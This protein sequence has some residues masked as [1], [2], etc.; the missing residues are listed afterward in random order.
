MDSKADTVDSTQ[1][2]KSVCSA[3][4]AEST[5]IPETIIIYPND[6]ELQKLAKCPHCSMKFNSENCVPITIT[7]GQTVCKSC[8]DQTLCAN[9]YKVHRTNGEYQP[10]AKNFVVYALLDKMSLLSDEKNIETEYPDIGDHIET[11]RYVK[12]ETDI[13]RRYLKSTLNDYKD[14]DY[15]LVR[16]RYLQATQSL[17]WFSKDVENWLRDFYEPVEGKSTDNEPIKMEKDDV[18]MEA[19]HCAVC[20]ERYNKTNYAPFSAFCGHTFCRKCFYKFI[21]YEKKY[22]FDCCLCCV[23]TVLGSPS[24]NHTAIKLLEKLNLLADNDD[25]TDMPSLDHKT[26]IDADRAATIKRNLVIRACERYVEIDLEVL[27][28]QKK[29]ARF[30]AVKDVRKQILQLRDDLIDENPPAVRSRNNN[31]ADACTAVIFI[32]TYGF[33]ILFF[34]ACMAVLFIATSHDHDKRVKKHDY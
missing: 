7:C 24:A 34:L 27:K 1:D 22:F 18:L 12:T 3:N 9:L 32:L 13:L 10:W 33:A 31:F 14:F 30:P 25:Q 17:D 28:F 4:S 15:I 2:T 8:V 23:R 19:I 26:D 16:D 5:V 21:K 11:F 20:C 6:P 29:Y